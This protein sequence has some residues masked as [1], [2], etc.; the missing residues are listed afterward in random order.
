[1]VSTS[2][3]DLAQLEYE[4]ATSPNSEAFIPLA[5][6]YLGMGRF[7]EAMVV[8]K[9]GIKAHPDLP[10]GRLIMA[11]IYSDQAK[12]QK[13][14]DELE[15]LLKLSPENAE[16]YHLL[17]NVQMKLG[18]EEQGV[19]HLKKALDID[20]D[21]T[22]A[23]E[24]L[25]KIGID[26]TPRSAAAQPAA[27]PAA[28][29]A[30]P[31][32]PTMSERPT[33]RQMPV[34]APQ[35]APDTQPGEPGAMPPAD[36]ITEPSMHVAQPRPAPRP[37][38]GPRPAHKRRI[39][40]IYNDMEERN[41]KPQ[42]KGIKYT[43]YMGGVLAVI[44][45]IYVIYTWQAG[46]K[47][48]KINDHLEKGRASFNQDTYAGYKK[49]LENYRAIYKLDK[50]HL[51]ALSRGAFICAVLPGEFSGPKALYQEGMKYINQA[52]ASKESNSML[53]AARGL[54]AMYA[55][56]NTNEARKILEEGLKEN[57]GSA[58]LH[59]AL[60][61]VLLKKG[62]LAEA[63]D[64]LMEG[65]KQSEIRALVGLGL[66]A[67]R[68][69][70]YREATQ[71]FHRALQ[72]DREHVKSTL[73]MGILALLWGDSPGRRK[74][75]ADMLKHFHE[76]ME[77][78][79][80]DNE[81]AYAELIDTVLKIR[82]RKTRRA[83]LTK[84]ATLMKAHSS[85][86]LFLFVGAKELRR[87]RKL[88]Q[89][90]EAIEKA[91]R[92]DGSRPDF[93]LEEAAIY[94]A[95]KDYE[96]T[97]SRAMRVQEMDAESGQASI[98]IGDAYL[99]EKNFEKAKQYY[100]EATK[101]EDTEALSHLRLG[102][103]FVAQTNPDVDRAQAQYEL[104]VPGLRTSGE[105]NLAS[106]TCVKLAKIYASKNRHKEF[107]NILQIAK[108]SDASNAEPYCMIAGNINIDTKDGREQAKEYCGNCVK[109]D[110][111]GEF[112]GHCKEVLKK[113]R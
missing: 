66:Y 12:H 10:T 14:I 81:K 56:S 108:K 82:E 100:K 86:A 64:H 42:R 71:A 45:V 16:A 37:R 32:A 25:L 89:A 48:K 77:A 55:S 33:E 41:R 13:A 49:A 103:A 44:L 80:S 74:V 90:K 1:M 67:M 63:R 11:R 39:A 9:K 70:M 95:M 88:K 94:L 15:K 20:P 96:G 85:D 5:E 17:G 40:D 97:R 76:E 28:Q 79:A 111:G 57:A 21:M 61:Y 104:A 68:R 30:S 4:F 2:S 27:Q 8:C 51:E 43:L 113:I 59:T 92:L 60:G 23:R 19:G 38:S 31:A 29:Q 36:I 18:K 47:Q 78:T 35:Q 98:L 105:G 91:L 101:F 69:T 110:A 107:L 3:N 34:V 62:E 112:S 83:G 24:A 102:D 93:A 72:S 84:L 7:V 106:Q 109:L 87:Q 58:V 52:L 73:Y 75:A 26:Y 46:I 6:A 65:A 50:N 99:G 53:T 54:M 22:A